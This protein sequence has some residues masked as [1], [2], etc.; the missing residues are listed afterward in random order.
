VDKKARYATEF[1]SGLFPGKKGA[2]RRKTIKS[3]LMQL[4]NSLGKVNDIVS[5]KTLFDDIITRP[6]RGLS[7]D[8]NIVV[9]L[10]R[11]L[12][13]GTSKLRLRNRSIARAKRTRALMAPKHSGSHPS[14]TTRRRYPRLKSRPK[15]NP[16][17]SP[18]GRRHSAPRAAGFQRGRKLSLP[19]P[20]APSSFCANVKRN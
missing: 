11:V 14:G 17:A 10:L 18:R 19:A 15:D 8:K 12:L 16:K 4:Q 20:S 13:F 1:F 5:H 6:T 7:D 3:S 9:C 2:R